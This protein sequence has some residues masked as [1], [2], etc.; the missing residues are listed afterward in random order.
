LSKFY[1]DVFKG[2]QIRDAV[3]VLLEKSAI[4]KEFQRE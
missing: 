3:E 2:S 1:D 4:E